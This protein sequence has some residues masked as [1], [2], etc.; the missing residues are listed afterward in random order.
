MK[1]IVFNLALVALVALVAIPQAFANDAT[2]VVDKWLDPGD[3]GYGSGSGLGKELNLF[4]I[5]NQVR[6][7]DD[8]ASFTWNNY[9]GSATSTAG[10]FGLEPTQDEIASLINGDSF[11]ASARARYAGYTQSFGWYDPS[12]G[13]NPT[14]HT[15]FDVLVPN[16]V[17]DNTENAGMTWDSTADAAFTAL[18]A[19]ATTASPF[20]FG[21]YDDAPVAVGFV[22]Y[23]EEARNADLDD[24]MIAF[25]VDQRASGSLTQFTYILAW[26]DLQKLGDIDYNDL[27]VEL[28]ITSASEP[29]RPIPEP[30]TLALLGLGAVGAFL[31]KRFFA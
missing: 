8:A 26:E 16:D 12:E 20:N 10:L 31:R 28:V 15:M 7:I 13:A 14:L 27:V 4:D 24:H 2:D 6:A 1:R 29:F 17:F 22:E 18:L 21:F 9:D 30:S 23:S 25:L 3:V 5:V 19:S 11:I